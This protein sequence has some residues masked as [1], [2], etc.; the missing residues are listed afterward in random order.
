M[1]ARLLST[2]PFCLYETHSTWGPACYAAG[3]IFFTQT[4]HLR[5]AH[6]AALRLWNIFEA[7]VCHCWGGLVA[8]CVSL[9]LVYSSGHALQHMYCIPLRIYA[10]SCPVM[11][12][13]IERIYSDL[14]RHYWLCMRESY[15]LMPASHSS[16]ALESQR[17]T[18]YDSSVVV[19]A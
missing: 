6:V 7:S 8:F 14:N 11:H 12:E 17:V 16:Y 9:T 1:S 19:N 18:A 15:R 3:V 4:Q 5:H 10:A 13:C 2:T